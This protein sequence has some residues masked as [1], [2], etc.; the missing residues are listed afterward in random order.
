MDFEKPLFMLGFIYIKNCPK[1]SA[2]YRYK[3][4]LESSRSSVLEKT[5][6]PLSIWLDNMNQWRMHLTQALILAKLGVCLMAL[7]KMIKETSI[8]ESQASW[9]D[10]FKHRS[11]LYKLWFQRGTPSADMK[12]SGK[13][14]S[15][16]RDLGH[17]GKYPSLVLNMDET[18]LFWKK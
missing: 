3:V 5:E 1:Q 2:S 11:K 10:R 15:T 8:I 18:G 7:K 14:P 9:F 17:S 16:F 4:N 13:Y 6:H 12:T